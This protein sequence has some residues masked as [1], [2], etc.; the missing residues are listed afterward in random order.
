M[1]SY[2]A[3][4]FGATGYAGAELIRRLLGH[5]S[6]DLLRACAVDHVGEPLSRAHPNL[7]AMTELR[8][9][10]LSPKD[11][12]AGADVVLLGLPSTVSARVMPQLLDAGVK[13]V[14]LSGAYRLKDPA[15]YAEFYGEEHPHPDLLDE[16]VYGLPEVAADR[17]SRARA[18]ASPGC[19]ATTVELG[20]IPLARAGLLTGDVP[21]VGITGSSGSG[22]M[23]SPTTHHPTRSGNL[24]AYRPLSHQHAPEIDHTLRQAGGSA[25][26]QFVPVSAPLTRGILVTSF[27]R[28][29]SETSET[30]IS[31]AFD[32]AYD[33]ARFV[34]R[35]KARLPEV[36]AVAGS[37]YAEVGYTLGQP[38]GE[39]T[40]V[41]TCFSALDNLVKGGAGQV[42]QNMNLMLGLDE[43]SSLEEP[44][45]YP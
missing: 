14:D 13:I 16:F 17:I 24:R 33:G 41:L 27:V 7:E 15:L 38:E 9:E 32:A 21:S 22:A 12:A 28:V 4:V 31:A 45:S 10:D 44:G 5:P 8:F 35:P 40:R 26:I 34:R 36:I 2:K 39:E 43:G 1:T 25:R 37:N 20:L 42:I 11:A 29:P 3:V 18:V 19:F 23:P 6:V 30:E